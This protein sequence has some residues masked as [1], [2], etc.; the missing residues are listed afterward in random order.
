MVEAE[1][2]SG[3]VFVRVGHE[4]IFD[5]KGS[6][7]PSQFTTNSTIQSETNSLYGGGCGQRHGDAHTIN[8]GLGT[9]TDN[10]NYRNHKGA[11]CGLVKKRSISSTLS[12]ISSSISKI[13]SP[14]NS[15]EDWS[16]GVL[17]PADAL[18]FEDQDTN[19]S[20]AFINKDDH[21]F[22]SNDFTGD[23]G[24]T[25]VVRC[26]TAGDENRLG[27][28]MAVASTDPAIKSIPSTPT[29]APSQIQP[30]MHRA[31]SLHFTPLW[32]LGA[33]RFPHKRSA[34]VIA[35]PEE[36]NCTSKAATLPTFLDQT[37]PVYLTWY[38][39][40]SGWNDVAVV[41]V[42]GQQIMQFVAVSSHMPLDLNV[43]RHNQKGKIMFS[44]RQSS[45]TPNTITV[46]GADLATEVFISKD[47]T[48]DTCFIFNAPDGH[49]YSWTAQYIANGELELSLFSVTKII[50]HFRRTNYS[51]T[52]L[53]I[54]EILP[55]A[56]HM[57]EIIA[58]TAYALATL[59]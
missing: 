9:P 59:F 15:D 6:L 8:S 55:E 36:S 52:R 14:Y 53:G 31:S 49:I 29:S 11:H 37:P 1:S 39:Q 42:S 51:F 50:C 38:L 26:Q 12:Y 44:I 5:D 22:M 4:P 56:A 20:P 2:E 58:A 32:A 25:H 7:M 21:V 43:H 24:P 41:D 46:V 48:S 28:S 40:R 34:S 17:P 30:K 54:F 13:L 16:F 10:Y 3:V 35:F 27:K 33:S 45:T 47:H 57:V 23:A 18:P 19:H